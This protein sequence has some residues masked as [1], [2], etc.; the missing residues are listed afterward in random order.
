[1]ECVI[2][3]YVDL[4][5]FIKSLEKHVDSHGTL[6][7]Y[8]LRL[9]DGAG[10]ES[11][12]CIL[13]RADRYCTDVNGYHNGYEKFTAKFELDLPDFARNMMKVAVDEY[14]EILVRVDTWDAIL[15]EHPE[16][17]EFYSCPSDDFSFYYLEPYL[18]D[19]LSSK[20][21]WRFSN[22][23]SIIDEDELVE[24]TDDN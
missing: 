24:N 2:R 15:A 18:N 12:N 16:E 1:M 6:S 11:G 3:K 17:T 8:E 7:S 20:I 14:A 4:S 5:C 23:W 22:G 19:V 21:F 13:V 10:W 9:K